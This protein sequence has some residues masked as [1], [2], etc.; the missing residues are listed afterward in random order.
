VGFLLKMTSLKEC[1][2]GNRIRTLLS[3]HAAKHTSGLK[4]GQFLL[5][6]ETRA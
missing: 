1:R 3:G 4:P 2:Y 5:G 6:Y